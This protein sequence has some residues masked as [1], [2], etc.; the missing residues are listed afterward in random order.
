MRSFRLIGFFC[1][2]AAAACSSEDGTSAPGA[3]RIDSVAVT[4]NPNMVVS[5]LVRYKGAGDSAYVVYRVAGTTAD[6][7]TPRFAHAHAGFDTIPVLGLLPSASYEFRLVVVSGTDSSLSDS[8]ELTTGALPADLP[9]Y[10]TGGSSPT[11]GFYSFGAN[12]YG[13]VIDHT[14]RVVW[15]KEFPTGG[16]GLNFEAQPV[17]RYVGRY[18]TADV[19]DDDPMME[20]DPAGFER[21]ALRCVNGRKLR[22][23]DMLVAPDS[24]Y[25]MLCDDTQILD[26]TP[27]GGNPRAQVTG[28]VIQHMGRS[29]SLLFEW[30]PFNQFLITDLD[31]I[32]RRGSTVNW[33]HG[34]AL[35]IDTDGNLLVSFRSL[36]EITKIN[37]QTGDIM[38]R[39][40]GRRNQFTFAGPAETGFF[41]QHSV[42]AVAPNTIIV[43]DNSGGTFSRFERYNINPTTMTA[44]LQQSY[45]SSPGVLTLVGGSVQAEA[46]GKFL[47]SFGTE[48]RVEEFDANGTMLWHILGNPGYVF[49][50]LRI[51]SL[52][53]P[54]PV[55][56]R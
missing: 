23:H 17:G 18:P 25:W 50:A 52:Y 27:Y 39:M 56:T 51:E 20:I 22:F 13:L 49:R 43:L 34:N 26:L 15:Y 53:H 36:S 42:R 33:T 10:A 21:R 35:E 4:A 30:S 9:A 24:S 29:G 14:G 46:A 19:T 38:W 7:V 2:L 47:V 32:D 1:L 44:T 16:P 45:V 11:P 55:Q 28:T 40:G 6:S 31:S 8:V 48:G 37:V 12:Q 3:T 41:R 54:V 5:A